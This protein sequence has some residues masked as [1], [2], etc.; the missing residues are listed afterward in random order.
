[1]GLS[2]L[3][4]TPILTAVL[5][6]NEDSLSTS[7]TLSGEVKVVT[8]S[9]ENQRAY[10]YGPQQMVTTD[11]HDGIYSTPF[12]AFVHENTPPLAPEEHHQ[13]TY[14]GSSE[15]S[16]QQTLVTTA[17]AAE[18]GE[19]K[20][21]Q[22]AMFGSVMESAFNELISAPPDDK[23]KGT[24]TNITCITSS[25]IMFILDPAMFMNVMTPIVMQGYSQGFSQ[26]FSIN[27]ASNIITQQAPHSD[28]HTPG[29]ITNYHFNNEV[30]DS[31][32]ISS[33]ST[34]SGGASGAS[35][36]EAEAK[37][38]LTTEVVFT[39]IN[40]E[41]R[42]ETLRLLDA[43]SASLIAATIA[44]EAMGYSNKK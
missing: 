42:H 2:Q 10:M 14:L 30:I 38:Q 44:A 17:L 5:N 33:V 41:P 8:P 24:T 3:R 6:E 29:V 18:Y 21:Q 25:L 27:S 22:M 16:D 23:L 9:P 39:A 12:S 15:N 13:S 36:A 19:E 7:Y 20:V 37:D 31:I 32:S 11:E 28:E 40:P 1:M 34:R 35:K 26:E 43:Y 4:G